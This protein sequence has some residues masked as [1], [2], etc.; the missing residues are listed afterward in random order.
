MAGTGEP[1][2]R[3][4]PNAWGVFSADT[5]R[6]LVFIPTGNVQMD[7]FGGDRGGLDR[8]TD[9]YS[10]SVV[11]LE[12]ATGRVVWHFQT[13]HH[14][15]WDYDVPAQPVLFDWPAESGT[16]P[17]L[18][19]PTKQGHL[20]VLNRET[21]Q[22]LV[23]V[24]ERPVPQSG[25]VPEEYLSPTQ[26]FPANDAFILRRPDLTEADMWGFTPWDRGKCRETFRRLKY[27][28]MYTPP[29]LQGTLTYPNNLG[30]MNWGSASIDPV[31]KL[32]VVN[33]SH[34]ATITTLIP[35]KEADARIAHGEWLLPQIG[36]PYAA[37]WTPLLS[38]WGAPCNRPPWGTLVAIDLEHR[39][40]AWEVSLGTTRD[41][42][43]FPLW[44]KLGTPNVGGPLTTASGLTFIGATT[45]NYLRAFDSETGKELWKGRLPAGPQATPMTYR[46]RSDGKQFVVIAAG[47]HRY[48]GTTLG[49]SLVAFSL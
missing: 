35:R 24:E 16:V 39:K 15:I 4:T 36:T 33:T 21:G 10:T 41:R 7:L 46:L 13:V 23:P 12:A 20:Y 14:D 27:D 34:V 22:P 17:A 45:D 25:A 9:Y 11:A 32:L 43:P 29:S 26:P 40:R 42:A 8:G 19:Q 2:V 1:F 6:G 5:N 3:A 37:S 44:L 49:D 18:V 28:G 31:H 38:P 30:I 47:G 48:L